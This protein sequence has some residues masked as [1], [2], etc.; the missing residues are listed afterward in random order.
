MACVHMAA[1]NHD[2]CVVTQLLVPDH[3]HEYFRTRTRKNKTK[4]NKDVTWTLRNLYK[5]L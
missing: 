3:A 1:F 4:N 5:R 2:V